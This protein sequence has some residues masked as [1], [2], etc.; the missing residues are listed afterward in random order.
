MKTIFLFIN[1]RGY[2]SDLLRGDYIKYLSSKYK[3]I[4]FLNELDDTHFKS[5]NITYIKFPLKMGKF[6]TLFDVL[7]RTSLIRRFDDF[8]GIRTRHLRYKQN[9]WRKNI[10]KK[11]AKLLPRNFFSPEFFYIFEKIFIPN[12]KLFKQYIDTYNPSLILTA[13]PGL[14]FMEA[15]AI[16]CAKKFNVPSVSFYFSWDNLTI[17]ARSVRKTD[18]MICWN[19]V[20]KK[21]AID[22]HKYK[23]NEV[24]VSGIIRFDHFFKDENIGTKEEFLKSKGLDPMKKTILVATATD[25][26]AD[27]YRNII[28]AVKDLDVN[29]YVRI[30]PIDRIRNYEDLKREKK[31]YIESAGSA[32]LSGERKGWQTEL[33]EKDRINVKKILKFSDLEINRASTMT[34]DT[35]A[36]NLDIPIINLNF[37]KSSI[38]PVVEYEHYK[39]IVD[40]GAVRVAYNIDE[41]MD[42]TEIYLKNPELDKENRKRIFDRLIKFDDSYS[43]KRNVDFLENILKKGK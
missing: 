24:F 21:E 7:F 9:D 35:F 10:L 31:V 37:K 13:T 22:I 17:Y 27:L 40:E 36:C 32:K 43:Y 5:D 16:L 11:V 28:K 6:W 33:E 19:E 2:I 20:I 12:T 23:D 41:V 1:N 38:V 8:V 18:Y 29:V 42:Y 34:L 39:P 15:W 30:H 25:V 14:M 26:D 4:V 3:V